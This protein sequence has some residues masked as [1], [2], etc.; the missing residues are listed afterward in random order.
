MCGGGQTL[1][2]TNWKCYPVTMEVCMEFPQNIKGGL[3]YLVTPIL[4]VY[5]EM[6]LSQY[7]VEVPMLC[8]TTQVMISSVLF[9]G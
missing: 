9:S 6:Y 4:G 7:T 1:I 3:F 5:M 2:H 8:I